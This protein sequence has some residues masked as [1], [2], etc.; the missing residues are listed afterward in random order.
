MYKHL[1]ES[2]LETNTVC[3]CS[4]VYKRKS[5]DQHS[6]IKFL[7]DLIEQKASKEDLMKLD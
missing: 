7:A 5:A 6:C 1:E 2:C 4:A 3:E